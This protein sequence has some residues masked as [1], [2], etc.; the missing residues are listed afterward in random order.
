MPEQGESAV[1]LRHGFYAAL[2]PML[3]AVGEDAGED[4][5]SDW[6]YGRVNDRVESNPNAPQ[7]PVLSDVSIVT[8][9]KELSVNVEE[10]SIQACF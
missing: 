4:H 2:K 3:T 5:G 7:C 1:L 6:R 9:I 8:S 10:I